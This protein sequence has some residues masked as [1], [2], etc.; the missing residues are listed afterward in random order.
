MLVALMSSCGRGNPLTF[1]LIALHR[2]THVLFINDMLVCYFSAT[3]ISW[4]GESP[5]GRIVRLIAYVPEVANFLVAELCG[6]VSDEGGEDGGLAT[7]GMR[8]AAGEV[9]VDAIEAV[10]QRR[11][12]E[13]LRLQVLEVQRELQQVHV[14]L[15]QQR[16]AAAEEPA[17]PCPLVVHVLRPADAAAESSR[18]QGDH[19]DEGG[20]RSHGNTTCSS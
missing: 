19:H 10:A 3:N 6:D 4:S 12:A 20:R 7:D 1:C 11:P 9:D 18:H 13:E 15:W 16:A 17:V 5:S 2:H 14:R 8:A